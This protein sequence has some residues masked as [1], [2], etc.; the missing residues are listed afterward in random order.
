MIYAWLE[1]WPLP[2]LNAGHL[3]QFVF[4]FN[5]YHLLVAC[6]TAVNYH[7]WKEVESIFISQDPG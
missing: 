2:A 7:V 3:L 1:G 4:I 5:G 6:E